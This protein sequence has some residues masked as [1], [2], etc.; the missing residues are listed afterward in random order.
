LLKKKKRYWIAPRIV[1]CLRLSFHD[2]SQ[3][4]TYRIR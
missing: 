3:K 1:E 2:Q 4:A